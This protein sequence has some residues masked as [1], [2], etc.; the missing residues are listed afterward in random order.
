[1][2]GYTSTVAQISGDDRL[3]PE[4]KAE[5]L[6][7]AHT[8]AQTDLSGVRATVEQQEAETVERLASSVFG[9]PASTGAGVIAARDADDRAARYP[10]RGGATRA[11]PDR[12][13]R[14]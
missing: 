4:A 11:E 14:R 9:N 12:G 1:L 8:K 10:S 13:E 6:A 3:T 7:Q 2:A 5:D